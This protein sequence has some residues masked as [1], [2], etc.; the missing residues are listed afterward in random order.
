MERARSR[1]RRIFA[2]CC[3]AVAIVACSGAN[4]Q[5]LALVKDAAT[6]TSEAERMLDALQ[7]PNEVFEAAADKLFQA[8]TLDPGYAKAYVQVC[9][10]EIMGGLELGR[11]F[12]PMSIETAEKAVVKALDFDPSDGY[13]WVLKAHL[14]V[15]THRLS[16]AKAAL[17]RAEKFGTDSSWLL[18]NWAEVFEEE[19]DL[20]RAAER[21]QAVLKSGTVN[22]RALR[23]AYRQL[24][25]YYILKRD[26]DNAEAMHVAHKQID[27]YDAWAPTNF[28]A[29]LARAGQFARALPRAR[30]ALRIKD[31]EAAR[32][33]LAI[34]LYGLWATSIMQGENT[35]DTAAYLSEARAIAP[36]LR[37]IA[38]E[39][40]A[41]INTRIISQALIRQSLVDREEI[42]RR[43]N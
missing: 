39:T 5:S 3:I 33:A 41:N 34:A 21:Y 36:N 13:A 1:V 22:K 15:D 29:A 27:P 40:Y 14:Y 18:L 11:R 28:A 4:A 2:A 10:L 26:W 6:L 35:T 32:R 31:Y 17:Y 42:F 23:Y 37:Q 24:T 7:V 9:R 12:A 25:G 20:E 38:L 16:E 43:S 30:E 8:I 19:G